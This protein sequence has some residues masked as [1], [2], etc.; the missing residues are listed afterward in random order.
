MMIRELIIAISE[1]LVVFLFIFSPFLSLLLSCLSILQRIIFRLPFPLYSRTLQYPFY[2]PYLVVAFSFLT[3]IATQ[4]F[5]RER[6]LSGVAVL[7]VSNAYKA[8]KQQLLL[9]LLFLTLKCTATL[10]SFLEEKILVAETRR[11]LRI[12]ES[13]INQLLFFL[14]T[15][16]LI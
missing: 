16:L 6:N 7:K 12:L 1:I 15:M 4:Y 13:F 14:T 3:L 8:S 10:P 9:V 2:D 5:N 11:V